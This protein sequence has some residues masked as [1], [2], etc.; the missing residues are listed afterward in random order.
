[1]GLD[2][3]VYALKMKQNTLD[4]RSEVLLFSDPSFRFSDKMHKQKVLFHD[5]RKHP[6]IHG[7]ME[8]RY[9]SR[10]GTEDFNCVPLY[11]T[12]IDIECL[13]K[14]IINKS[15]PKTSGFFFG[16]SNEEDYQID[17]DF[18]KKAKMQQAQGFHIF[19][20]SWW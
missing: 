14:D 9:I 11:L 1:M 15:L 16:E 20:D 19:Y 2:Q 8:E 7:W 18:I 4:K 17:M 10:G 3:Y 13:E 5:W 12:E 6:D